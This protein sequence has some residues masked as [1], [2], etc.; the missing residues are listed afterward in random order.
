MR[1]L[2]Q[3]KSPITAGKDAQERHHSHRTQHRVLPLAKSRG[4]D[5]TK[6]PPPPSSSALNPVFE[7]TL[8]EQ[9]MD[10]VAGNDR[11]QDDEKVSAYQGI[12]DRYAQHD[13]QED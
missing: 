2:L 4:A 12:K 7:A 8:A 3:C 11:K 10:D 6:V 5:T 9:R 1:T 13:G